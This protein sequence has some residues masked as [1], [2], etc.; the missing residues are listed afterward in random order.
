MVKD[1][2]ADVVD[3][4]AWSDRSDEIQAVKD[5]LVMLSKKFK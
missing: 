2:V 5:K 4:A 1:N 3:W